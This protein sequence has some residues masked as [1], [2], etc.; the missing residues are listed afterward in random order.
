MLARL[1]VALFAWILAAVPV[2]AQTARNLA[3]LNGPSSSAKLLAD[4]SA[5]TAS[6]LG[7]RSSPTAL[8][9]WTFS[10]GTTSNGAVRYA[11]NSAGQLVAFAS[12]APRITDKGLLIEEGR[13][14]LLVWSQRF[15][16]ASWASKVGI[17]VTPAAAAAPDG[18]TTA[19][20]I[21][22][23]TSNGTHRVLQSGLALS[24]GQ[25]YTAAYY[26]KAVGRAWVALNLA[27][28][29][30]NE[31]AYYNL[32]SGTVGSVSGGTASIYPLANGWWRVSLSST[33]TATSGA[34]WLELASAN[35]T[36]SYT[37]AGTVGAYFWQADVQPGAFVTSPIV[38]T[39]ASATRA[40]DNASLTGLGSS[41][42]TPVTLVAWGATTVAVGPSDQYLASLNDGSFNNIMGVR[43][44]AASIVGPNSRVAGNFN[45]DPGQLAGYSGIRVLK[46]AGRVRPNSLQGAVDGSLLASG[47]ITNPSNLGTLSIGKDNPGGTNYLNGYVQRVGIYGDLS[48]AALSYSTIGPISW[49]NFDARPA[50]DSTP[51]LWSLAA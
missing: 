11:E 12:G 30:G 2:A 16:D 32:S 27:A 1:L 24:S 39:T 23:D 3:V 25:A 44:S 13:Q 45:S 10:G 4:F 28:G 40:A 5:N 48:D 15:D 20:A 26:V 29:F 21:A 47:A 35:G 46:I 8:T 31:R 43:R 7:S 17:N 36:I 37:G 6:Y 19:Q 38:T 33:A 49:A 18:T 9:G 14:N 34:I 51:I 41:L 50:P 42:S 22:E